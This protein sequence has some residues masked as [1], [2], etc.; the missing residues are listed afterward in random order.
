MPRRYARTASKPESQ[1]VKDRPATPR[2]TVGFHSIAEEDIEKNWPVKV[3]KQRWKY[4]RPP[5]LRPRAKNWKGKGY[6]PQQMFPE[7][8]WNTYPLGPPLDDPLVDAYCDDSWGTF[9]RG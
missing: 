5:R 9:L 6:T 3:H 2:R 1:I 8:D 7:W 4:V